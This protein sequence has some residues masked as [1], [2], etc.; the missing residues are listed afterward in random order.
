MV[1]LRHIRIKIV[2]I[3]VLKPNTRVDLRQGRV[4]SRVGPV[5]IRIIV[6]III[7]KPDLRVNLG[8]GS[9][10]ISGGSM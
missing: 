6:I 3:I 1:Q 4:M 2:I 10:H 7:L 8:Q 9:G 5:S